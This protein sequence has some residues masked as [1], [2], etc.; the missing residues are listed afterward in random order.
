MVK[1]IKNDSLQGLEIYLREMDG[2]VISVWLPPRQSIAVEE[3][4]IT[5]HVRTLQKRGMIK[6][7]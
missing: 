3:S 6:V 4:T 1:K 2:G 7:I 5:K